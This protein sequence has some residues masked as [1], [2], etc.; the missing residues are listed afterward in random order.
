M[1]VIIGAVITVALVI[2][3]CGSGGTPSAEPASVTS[4]VTS[5]APASTSA[6]PV[7]ADVVQSSSRPKPASTPMGLRVALWWP[8]V[9][10]DFDTIQSDI[11]EIVKESSAGDVSGI[12]ETC[13]TLQ[14][15][16]E[17]MQADPPAPDS[18]LRKFYA[19]TLSA[20]HHGATACVDGDYSASAG[21][22][23]AATRWLT[24]A[25]AR[26]NHLSS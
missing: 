20:W 26:V 22:I 13:A 4:P 18:T 3:G 17:A 11:N 6:K 23:K 21:Y 24:K 25:T 2:A 7:A 1:K 12:S 9:S 19:R 10:G 15:D 5:A 16:V 14:A 8:K